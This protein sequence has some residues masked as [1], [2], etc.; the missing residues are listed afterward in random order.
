M[1]DIV[2]QGFNPGSGYNI[3]RSYGTVCRFSANAGGM[4]DIVT[5]G[6][7]PGNRMRYNCNAGFYP[8]EQDEI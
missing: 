3:G 6:F 7:N 4:T 5:Q 2:T 1:T 8:W